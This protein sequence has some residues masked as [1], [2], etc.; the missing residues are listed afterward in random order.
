MHWQRGE[1]TNAFLKQ[2]S[3]RAVEASNISY[4]Q[5]QVCESKKADMGQ[6]EGDAA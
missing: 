4:S 5:M 3:N 1:R 2:S 6:S